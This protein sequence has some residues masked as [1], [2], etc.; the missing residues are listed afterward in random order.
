MQDDF[1]AGLY[2]KVP[3]LAAML[4]N[5]KR[6]YFSMA[7]RT[8]HRRCAPLRDAPAAQVGLHCG[9]LPIPS[10]CRLI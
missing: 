4:N 2:V 1:P 8:L 7:H 9:S 3:N 10:K 6:G 5:F